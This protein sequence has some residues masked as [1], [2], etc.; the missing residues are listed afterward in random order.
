MSERPNWFKSERKR[1][2][3][4]PVICQNSEIDWDKI[5]EKLKICPKKAKEHHRQDNEKKQIQLVSFF[6]IKDADNSHESREVCTV[7]NVSK[8]FLLILV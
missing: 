5:N 2:H 1:S 7:Y 8:R 3:E 4:A 6:K